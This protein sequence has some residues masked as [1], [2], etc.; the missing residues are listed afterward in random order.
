MTGEDLYQDLVL[1]AGKAGKSLTRFVAPI[2]SDSWKIEQLRFARR[3]LPLTI[4]RVRALIDGRPIPG[5]VYA[6]NTDRLLP[7]HKS[8]TR[9][10]AE[11]MGLPPSRRSYTERRAL[12]IAQERRQHVDR[13]RD[14]SELARETRK[15]GQA[16]GE[17]LREL[18]W[19]MAA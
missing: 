19:E 10:Q 7:G 4:E 5:R 17:R 11:G 2:F 12:Q 1:A 6:T 8:K 16:L 18:Q 13:L 3:P 9:E 14:L 15:P